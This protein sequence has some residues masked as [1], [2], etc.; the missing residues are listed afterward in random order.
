MEINKGYSESTEE[1]IR[2]FNESNFI[3]DTEFIL[4][5]SHDKMNKIYHRADAFVM[6]SIQEGQ[7]VSA[8]EAAC[9]GLPIFSTRCGGVEDYVDENI[10]RIVNINDSYILAL[11]LKDFLENKI[12]FNREYIREVIINR[13]GKKIFVNNMHEAFE[14]VMN[15]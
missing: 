6:T 11:H 12:N 9:T 14:S 15:N 7:P 4:G 5:V 1:I 10:G 2:L 8:I 13:F 3:E